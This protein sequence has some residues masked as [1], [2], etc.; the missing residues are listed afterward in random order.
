MKPIQLPPAEHLQTEAPVGRSPDGAGLPQ[1]A[2]EPVPVSPLRAS[3]PSAGVRPEHRYR[4]E[5]CYERV[6]KHELLR[7]PSPFKEEFDLVACP[8][9]REA[10]DLTLICDYG[11]CFHPVSGGH[12]TPDGGYVNRCWDHS[13][14]NPKFDAQA[15]EAR[16]AETQSGGGND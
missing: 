11:D 12:P 1:Q 2:V 3:I 13:P 6:F 10:E 5:C 14:G 4:C 16:R 9:C 7:A 15:I 8:H